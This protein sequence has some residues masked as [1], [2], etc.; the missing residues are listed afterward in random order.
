[1][2]MAQR[3]NQVLKLM[4]M[5]VQQ[6]VAATIPGSAVPNGRRGTGGGASTDRVQLATLR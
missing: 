2:R 4:L 3:A 1:M 6:F 5:F